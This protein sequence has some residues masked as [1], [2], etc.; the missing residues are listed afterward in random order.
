MKM[1][2]WPEKR[3]S[4]DAAAMWV[5]KEDLVLSRDEKVEGRG[6]KNE[7][8]VDIGQKKQCFKMMYVYGVPID[9]QN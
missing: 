5:R 2:I 7:T 4:T 6:S 1:A 8:V 9:Q 3:M